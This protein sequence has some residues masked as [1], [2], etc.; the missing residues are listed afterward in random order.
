MAANRKELLEALAQVELRI[1]ESEQRAARVEALAEAMEVLGKDTQRHQMLIGRIR[2]LTVEYH[3]RRARLL[4][5][6][7]APPG[8]L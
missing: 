6:L 1:L 7:D 4:S 5:A 2:A 8:A 3:A